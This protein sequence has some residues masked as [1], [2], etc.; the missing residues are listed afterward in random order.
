MCIRDRDLLAPQKTGVYAFHW[1]FQSDNGE[2]FGGIRWLQIGVTGADPGD[3]DTRPPGDLGVEFGMNINP[4]AHDLDVDKLS[5]LGWVRWV[6]WAS[7]IKLSPEE[8]YQ[9]KYRSLI[10]TYAA[11]GV[12]SLIVLHQDTEWGNAP[13]EHG[14]WAAYAPS[15]I[16][17]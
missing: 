17:I 16:H 3:G 14:G 2:E 1:Q 4:E 5:G 6:F 13:W 9:Q 7:R 8:A 11:A 15:L 12:R 10:Q